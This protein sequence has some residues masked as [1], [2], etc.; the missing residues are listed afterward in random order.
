MSLDNEAHGLFGLGDLALG[1]GQSSLATRLVVQHHLE[2]IQRQVQRHIHVCLLEAGGGGSRGGFQADA[3]VLERGVDDGL[4]RVCGG[5]CGGV[6]FSL[7]LLEKMDPTYICSQRH[8]EW[9]QIG[10][11]PNRWA[12]VCCYWDVHT[13]DLFEGIPHWEC[14]EARIEVSESRFGHVD[15]TGTI[16]HFVSQV[17]EEEKNGGSGW[18][19]QLLAAVETG[20]NTSGAV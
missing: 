13:L 14:M 10:Q 15:V 4:L 2:K 16:W 8:C 1:L 18:M 17:G 7:G 19:R 11:C 9:R 6:C 5:V 12:K 3:H 20:C